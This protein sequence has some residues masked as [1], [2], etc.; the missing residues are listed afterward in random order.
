MQVL[1]EIIRADL[2]G[3]ESMSS[4]YPYPVPLHLIPA[5]VYI[6]IRL[7]YSFLNISI[8]TKKKASLKA[9]GI[10]KPG[11]V[12]TVYRKDYLWLSQS[13]MES[14]F[15]LSVIPANVIPCGPIFLSSAPAALQDPELAAWLDKSPTVLINLG[16]LVDYDETLATEMAK[17]V[18]MLLMETE[19]Q[20]LWKFKKRNI[21]GDGFLANLANEIKDG[22]LRLEGWIKPDPAALLETRNIVLA[23]HHGG[24][25]CYHEAFGYVCIKKYGVRSSH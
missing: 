2:M 5:N 17:A 4:G 12:F 3:T 11:D 24:A 20:V 1:R 18:K 15:P 14:D 21:F 22:R 8:L 16:S 7:I 25:N 19:V 23:V 10:A 6:N 13:S 9:N